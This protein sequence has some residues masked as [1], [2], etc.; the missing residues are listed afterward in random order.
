M[1]S[2]LNYIRSELEKI[3]DNLD[4]IDSNLSQI[5]RVIDHGLSNIVDALRGKL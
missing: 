4:S 1:E 2:D 5:A 3:N